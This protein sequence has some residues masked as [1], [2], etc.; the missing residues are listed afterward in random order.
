MKTVMGLIK[1]NQGHISVNS[2]PIDCKKNRNEI[3]KKLAMLFQSSALFDSMTILQNV[4][5]PLF[6]H[7]NLTFLEIQQKVEKVLNLVN[8]SNDIMN[9][10]PSD[11]SGGMKKRAA[12]ARAIINEPEYIIY[13]EPTTGLDPLTADEIINLINNL[14][15]ELSMTS[16]VIT[17]DPECIKSVTENLIM[18]DRTKIVYDDIFQNF[19]NCQDQTAKSFIKYIF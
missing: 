12:L 19:K 9:C 2:I 15:K 4:G 7:T 10:Y 11:L 14:H 3:K 17:H 8:L 6:E 18:L 16:I 1:P 5:F 13:D